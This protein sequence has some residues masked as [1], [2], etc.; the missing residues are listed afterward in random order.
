MK[1]ARSFYPSRAPWLFSSLT[2]SPLQ[3]YSFHWVYAQ[4]LLFIFLSYECAGAFFL[5]GWK[6][7]R[8]VRY[9]L[10]SSLLFFRRGERFAQWT[11]CGACFYGAERALR[12]VGIID[13]SPLAICVSLARK[14]IWDLFC[15]VLK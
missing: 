14:E 1:C 2:P 11:V 8:V 12:F 5:V 3:C 4:V 6:G 9:R 7:E 10:E 15:N 13:R